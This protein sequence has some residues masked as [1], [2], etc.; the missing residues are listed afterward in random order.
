MQALKEEYSDETSSSCTND[1]VSLSMSRTLSSDPE[2]PQG[3]PRPDGG[4]KLADWVN[5]RLSLV[6]DRAPFAESGQ[7]GGLEFS[8]GS[9]S[10]QVLYLQGNPDGNPCLVTFL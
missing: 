10:S 6:D 1:S 2:A 3:S 9:E 8:S 5:N 7:Q 4:R